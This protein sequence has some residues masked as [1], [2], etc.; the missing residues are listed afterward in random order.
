MS[1]LSGCV[2]LQSCSDVRSD[3]TGTVHVGT[4]LEHEAL[5]LHCIPLI[6]LSLLSFYL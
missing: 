2:S 3:G 4:G 5:A 1:L 6:C